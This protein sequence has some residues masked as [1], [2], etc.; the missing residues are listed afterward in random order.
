[1]DKLNRSI[2]RFFNKATT[3]L[4]F[5]SGFLIL[6]GFIAMEFYGNKLTQDV[7][8]LTAT[9]LSGAP[10]LHRALSGLRYKAVGIE[11]LVSIAVIGA[12]FIGEYTEAAVVTFLFQFGSFLEQRTLSKTRSAIKL[13]TE[14]APATAWRLSDPGAEAEEIDADDVEIDDLLLVKTGGK[15]A[16]DGVITDGEGYLN[17]ASING[18][19]VP[20]HKVVGDTVYAGT[21]LD[22]GHIQMR[23]TRVGED[24]SFAKII[25]LVEEAQDAKSP[26]ERFIDRFAKWYTPAVVVLAA[27]VYLITKNLE[28]AITVLVLGCPG[29]LVIGAPVANV[30]GIGRGARDHVLLK[31]GESV[32]TFAKTDVFL[33]D[34]TGT[35]TIGRP[36]V[37]EIYH[38]S[39][40]PEL[41]LTITAL[42]EKSS[43]HP[44]AKAIVNYAKEQ[45]LDLDE[46]VLTETHKGRGM[47]ATINGKRILVGN[48]RLMTE[49]GMT[50]SEEQL[51]DT[52][53]VQNNGASVVLV[54]EDGVI[55]LLLGVADKIKSDAREAI[56][57]LKTAGIKRTIMLTGDN[58]KTA[59]AV[60]RQIGIDE[61]RAELLPED[62][63]TVV[64]ELQASGLNVAFVGDGVNDSPALAQADTGIGMGGGTD[65]AIETSDVVLIRSELSSVLTALR[66]SKKTVRVLRQNIIIA[67][68]TVLMLLLGLFLGYVY[69]SIGMLVHEASILVVILNAMRLLYKRKSKT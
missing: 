25:A 47:E 63:L 52:A 2:S 44:L 27:L 32:S 22:G 57:A 19:S 48:E 14:M 39:D 62:K 54:A 60:A 66:L 17:E 16:V 15:V 67:V 26:A 58:Q 3:A 13:L 4:T 33:F 61:V 37:T 43:D 55:L 21:L 41:A 31:G 35:L 24:T 18:E 46:V 51:R 1:M 56:A 59:A 42:V 53:S 7:T 28:I 30:A 34:K 12:L 68:G 5:I 45:N 36:D 20:A 40:K 10:I 8:Y 64:H 29:A 50:L 23:A 9:V 49:N 69:M 65:V 38:Y 11:V 6:I